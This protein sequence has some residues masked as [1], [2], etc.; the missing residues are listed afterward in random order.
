[1]AVVSNSSPLI[2]FAAIERFDLLE[3][4]FGRLLIPPEVWNEVVE[5]G[6]DRPG[7]KEVRSSAW[8]QVVPLADDRIAY[9]FLTR[10]DSGE[11]HAIALCIE[12]P[13]VEALVIDDFA[14]RRLA[15]SIG[16]DVVGSAGVLV[17]AKER[18]IIRQVKPLLDDLVNAGLYMSESAI[19]QALDAADEK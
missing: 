9:Q 14:G 19:T 12:R 3:A 4:V 2:L 17:R 11:A 10:L 13:D 8:L 15:R 16:L 6:N 1:M 5:R 7:I 18:G